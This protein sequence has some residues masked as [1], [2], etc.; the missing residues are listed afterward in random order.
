MAATETPLLAQLQTAIGGL[1]LAPDHP[2]RQDLASL[3]QTG[4]AIRI[5]VFAPFNYGKSTLLNAM[6]GERT[7]PM[8]LIPTTGAA[9]TVGYG[10][11]LRTQICLKN[12]QSLSEPGTELLQQ[13]AIL[14]GER[15]MREDVAAVQVWY[16]HPWLQTGVELLDLPGTDDREAQDAL[17]RERL[18][19]ADLIVQVLDGRKLMTLG[20]R[21]HLRDWLQDRGIETV[22]FVVNF[23]NLLEPEE[24][25]Q[26]AQRLRFVAESFR[27]RLPAGISNL[28]RVDALPALRARLKGDAATAQVTGLPALEAALQAIVQQQQQQGGQPQSARLVSLARKVSAALETKIS[29][30]NA[31]MAAE[32]RRRQAH[33]LQLKQ[34][35]Q[36][37]LQQGY[38]ESVSSLRTWLTPAQLFQTYGQNLAIALELGDFPIWQATSLQPAW[39]SHCQAISKW[40]RQACEFFQYPPAPGLEFTFPTAPLLN[41]PPMP[42]PRTGEVKAI[43]DE[44]APVA[45]ATG[46]GLVLG[47]PAGAAV[48]GGASLILSQLTANKSENRSELPT[49]T[50]IAPIEQ[51]ARQAATDYLTQVSQAG[52]QALASYEAAVAPIINCPLKVELREQATPLQ[53]QLQFLQSTLAQLEECLVQTQAGKGTD[54]IT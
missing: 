17:V 27:S 2:L 8:D 13:Y 35:A 42:P 50:P 1:E 4:N 44:A 32:T 28:Y 39:K 19:G 54:N 49:A 30:V 38:R 45:I 15:R 21:E 26:V 31:E 48:L 10:P 47:G 51:I 24:Q 40:V 41:I 20:E 11:E 12:G 6:L 52:L 5:A 25:K 22:V 7:L 34:R 9:I 53:H 46:L 33:Q 29:Q 37:L 18:L 16:P 36:A 23:L 43:A 14:D 3:S